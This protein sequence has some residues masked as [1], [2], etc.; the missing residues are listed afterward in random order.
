MPLEIK[1][2]IDNSQQPDTIGLRSES[3]RAIQPKRSLGKGDT[4]HDIIEN[5][6]KFYPILAGINN[7]GEL[8]D[9]INDAQNEFTECTIHNCYI[10][11]R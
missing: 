3:N 2:I 8:K 11:N 5:W 4:F 6:N 1:N 7:F 10:C 9:K